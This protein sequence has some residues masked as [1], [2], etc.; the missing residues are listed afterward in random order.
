MRRGELLR[1]TLVNGSDMN[2]NLHGHRLE[3][4][5]K[6]ISDNIFRRAGPGGSLLYEFHIPNDHPAGMFW[7]HPHYP[8]TPAPRPS[9]GWPG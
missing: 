9:S 4:S 2:T 7:Y 6:G 5:P 1:I 8:G 3:V